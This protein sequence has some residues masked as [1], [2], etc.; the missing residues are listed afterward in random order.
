MIRRGVKTPKGSGSQSSG[1][2]LRGRSGNGPLARKQPKPGETGLAVERD[3]R[4]GRGR[5][6]EESEVAGREL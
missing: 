5:L 4:T 3:G 6:T 2:D 1:T